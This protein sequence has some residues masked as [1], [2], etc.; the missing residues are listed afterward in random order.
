[1]C[2]S[3]K[4]EHPM[5]FEC[6]SRRR[7]FPFKLC[8][9]CY[10]ERRSRDGTVDGVAG[11]ISTGASGFVSSDGVSGSST[12]N[13]A[14]ALHDDGAAKIMSKLSIESDSDGK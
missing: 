11:A 7:N 13:G 5:C 14:V 4:E 3:C 9:K 8:E 10:A 1:M 2:K 6:G 12:G